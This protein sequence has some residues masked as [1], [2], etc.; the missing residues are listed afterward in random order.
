M[1]RDC[2]PPRPCSQTLATYI[3]SQVGHSTT[4][5][6]HR[7]P[8][9]THPDTSL[10]EFFEF[11]IVC[12]IKSPGTS[13][14]S[15]ALGNFIKKWLISS[16]NAHPLLPASMSK[17]SLGSINHLETL[18]GAFWCPSHATVVIYRYSVSILMIAVGVLDLSIAVVL[19][20]ST[21]IQQRR[22][23]P[24]YYSYYP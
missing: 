4:A 18:K 12:W 6:A 11:I 16:P 8:R 2:R 20:L 14:R 22:S 17:T 7:I 23:N 1:Q 19:Q 9:D 24:F 5:S 3:I 21:M 13:W 15:T 10:W